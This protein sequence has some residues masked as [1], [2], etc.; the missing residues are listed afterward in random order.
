MVRKSSESVEHPAVHMFDGG[1]DHLLYYS[2][3]VGAAAMIVHLPYVFGLEVT[4]AATI[5]RQLPWSL[6]SRRA[7]TCVARR[8]PADLKLPFA[9]LT[10]TTP[11]VERG[12]NFF[13]GS[14]V[15]ALDV[16][17][18]EWIVAIANSLRI[19]LLDVVGDDDGDPVLCWFALAY[20]HLNEVLRHPLCSLHD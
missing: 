17:L 6:H 14:D 12:Q 20:A 8:N 7:S 13:V 16:V 19:E 11:L 5:W 9:L 3:R 18:L 2:G 10:T 15:F 1:I 4:D